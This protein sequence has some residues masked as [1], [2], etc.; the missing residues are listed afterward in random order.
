MEEGKY[1]LT[2]AVGCTGGKHRSVSVA[3]ELTEVIRQLGHN[4][5]LINRDAEK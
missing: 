3:R 4:A 2:I 1:T 5:V